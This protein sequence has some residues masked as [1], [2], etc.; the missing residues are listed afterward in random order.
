M[1]ILK[2]FKDFAIKG[3][4]IDL[5]VAVIIGAA[6]GKIVTS[7]VNDILMPPIGLMVGGVD[8]SELK[9]LLK[10]GSEG[11][12]PVT[13]N[14]GIFIQTIID[15]IIIAFSVFMV[16]RLYKQT[17]RKE[18]AKPNPPSPQPLTKEETLLTE[19]RDIL[20]KQTV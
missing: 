5:A 10:K 4:V 17:E 6:F 8:F 13:I 12:D 16:V 15:F 20:Q 2:D 7:L 14:Y 18:E 1:G 9:L 19:I 3:N 11:V